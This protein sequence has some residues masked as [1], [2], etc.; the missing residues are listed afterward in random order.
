MIYAGGVLVGG[1]AA[2]IDTGKASV[3]LGI[4]ALGLIV[5]SIVGAIIWACES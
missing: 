5:A 2:W 1:A 4:V 3:A